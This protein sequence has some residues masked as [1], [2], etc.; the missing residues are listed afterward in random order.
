MFR[1]TQAL[2]FD[3]QAIQDALA[4]KPARE[5]GSQELSTY[6]FTAPFVEGEDA[7]L[8]N[9]SGDFLMVCA[10]KASRILPPAAIT[11]EVKRKIK[12]IEAEQVRKVYKKSVTSSATR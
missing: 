12:A 6:G 8:V 5:P 3:P 2:P 7:P 1:L 11:S 9:V 10:A 4:S